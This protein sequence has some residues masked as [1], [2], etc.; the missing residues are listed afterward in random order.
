MKVKVIKHIKTGLYL[1]RN[2]TC[3]K[4]FLNLTKVTK[5]ENLK[6][7]PKS[8]TPNLKKARICKSSASYFLT[9]W[10]Y[11][12]PH[13][14][15]LQDLE[16]KQIYAMK[17]KINSWFV[18]EEI[19]A[20]LTS[21]K[22]PKPV[23]MVVKFTKHEL[24]HKVTT[25]LYHENTASY[26]RN[27][28]IKLKD[29]PFLYAPISMGSSSLCIHCVLELAEQLKDMAKQVDPIWAQMVVE[30]RFLKKL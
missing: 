19:D 4:V 12:C 7:D 24:D 10:Y 14:Y 17:K 15:P 2:K 29:L 9:K 23:K 1:K 22:P 28:G 30:E 5:T 3:E 25:R 16:W 26:C 13:K 6:I 18:E 11:N 8:F 20:D 21:Y 27:C